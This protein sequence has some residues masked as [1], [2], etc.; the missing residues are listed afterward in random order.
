VNFQLGS[1]WRSKFPSTWSRIQNGQYCEA[2]NGLES[3]LWNRQTPVR[4]DD[5]QACLRDQ[6]AKAGSPC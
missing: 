1:G 2:A 5:F 3:S 6:A 4:V